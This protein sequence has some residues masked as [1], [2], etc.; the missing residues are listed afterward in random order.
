MSV[1]P[2]FTLDTNV[3]KKTLDEGALPADAVSALK[4]GVALL[5]SATQ[6]SFGGSVRP[7]LVS[8]RS[9]AP[10]SMP[11][12][13]DTILNVG[14][15]AT[16]TSA[17]AREGGDELA[18]DIRSRFHAQFENVVGLEPPDDPLQQLVEAATAVFRSW[19][20]PRARTYRRHHGLSDDGGTAVTIQAMVFGNLDE[21]SG[22]GVLFSR[23]PS[24]GTAAI[25]G[26]WLPQAQGEDVVSGAVSPLPLSDMAVTHP[27]VYGEL[28]EA[29]VRLERDAG[30]VQD[31]EFTVESG[32][33]WLL[34]T[35]VAK[36]SVE[37]NL[38]IAVGLWRDGVITT[39]EALRRITRADVAA[40]L[41][42]RIGPEAASQANVVAT[43]KAASP[44]IGYGVVVATADEAVE[45]AEAGRTVVLATETTSPDDVHGMVASVAIVT[46]LGGST[47]HAAVV[48]RELGRPAVVG[49]G[50]GTL[51][52]LVGTEVTVDGDVGIVYAGQLAV[53]EAC[54]EDDPDLAELIRWTGASDIKA[55]PDLLQTSP[56]QASEK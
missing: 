12:M 14:T 6:S 54:S 8:V 35:R 33:L 38:R 9:G 49:C 18:L 11:G 26:E 2:A 7:L 5:E 20:S 51:S 17:L 22:T 16:T 53:V 3:C 40:M 45:Q 21:S 56:P 47:S 46:E 42:P 4:R 52:Q 31:I 25:V 43:G 44:G 55:L 36:R 1:P 24:T 30:D 32:R 37:A 29:A 23:N 50:L 10:R 39:D 48:S 41:R 13:L 15:N 28:I 34:Q 27:A 19:H